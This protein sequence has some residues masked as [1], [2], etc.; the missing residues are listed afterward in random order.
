MNFLDKYNFFLAKLL[1]SIQ[2]LFTLSLNI[3]ALLIVSVFIQMKIS[4]IVNVNV[5]LRI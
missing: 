2:G 4:E 1:K 3:T 5:F